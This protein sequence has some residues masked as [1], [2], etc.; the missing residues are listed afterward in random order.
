MEAL[1][2]T[3][4]RVRVSAAVEE[5]LLIHKT[6]PVYPP[7]A[8]AKHIE[9]TVTLAIIVDKQGG[10]IDLKS[11]S[12]DPVLVPAAM[13]AVKQWRYEEYVL[14]GHPVEVET[15]VQVN[16]RLDQQ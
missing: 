4:S 13:S 3:Y 9:G 11:V 8:K 7:E 5:Q 2:P 10:V 6:S 1:H 15:T 16:F 14:D 12:G